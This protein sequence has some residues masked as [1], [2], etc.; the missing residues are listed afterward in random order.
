MIAEPRWKCLPVEVPELE[1]EFP[2]RLSSYGRFPACHCSD[3][4]NKADGMLPGIVSPLPPTFEV[5][6]P[7]HAKIQ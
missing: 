1:E 5:A 4:V 3:P 2:C 7:G 6:N